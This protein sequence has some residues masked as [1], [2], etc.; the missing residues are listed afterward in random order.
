MK[1][2][3]R[4]DF[5]TAVLA[6]PSTSPRLGSLLELYLPL[7]RADGL[8]C[9]LSLFERAEHRPGEA[10]AHA[11]LFDDL[12]INGDRFQSALTSLEAV[13]LIR[14]FLTMGDDGS[15][16][17]AYL[18]YSPK[19]PDEFLADPLLSA[20]YAEMAGGKELAALREKYAK[21]NLPGG[22]EIT[23]SFNEVFSVSARK[24]AKGYAPSGSAEVKVDFDWSEC[25]AYLAQ[26]GFVSESFSQREKNLI[27]QMGALYSLT[28]EGMAEVVEKSY[29]PSAR[30]GQ[31]IDKDKLIRLS[32]DAQTFSYLRAPASAESQSQVDADT[33][34]AKKMQYYDETA[35]LQALSNLQGGTELSPYDQKTIAVLVGLG[36]KNGPI[37]ALADYVIQTSNGILSRNSC[38]RLGAALKRQGIDNAR[39]A[40]DYLNAM[41]KKRRRYR[42][43]FAPAE[44]SVDEAGTNESQSGAA[45]EEGPQYTEED[46]EKALA[47]LHAKEEKK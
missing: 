10:C 28:P 42:K 11:K 30:F 35:P 15:R 43:G 13:G 17:F 36:L 26:M 22:E 18:V 8:A 4:S 7:L 27:R 1:E 38:E 34:I 21:T 25:L 32:R 37:N 47:R 23:S 20:A 46:A 31:R 41:A 16:M 9:Y 14:S 44:E 24:E 33:D 39:D 3:S 12:A 29:S 5:L 45:E 2:V 6:S 40:M 19:E